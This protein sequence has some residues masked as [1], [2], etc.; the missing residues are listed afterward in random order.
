M[1]NAEALELRI[2]SGNHAGA[3]EALGASSQSLGTSDECDFVLSDAGLLPQQLRLESGPAGWCLLGCSD[4]SEAAG[5]AVALTPGV[6]QKVG[7]L[8]I[9]VDRPQAPWPTAQQ[10]NAL[11]Q[12]PTPEAH[13]SAALASPVLEE[14]AESVL[15]APSE[16][17][18]LAL[19]A[20]TP[21]PTNSPIARP[22]NR[23]LIAS[24]LALIVCALV[25][26]L[27]PKMAPQGANAQAHVTAPT[28]EAARSAIDA[29]IQAQGLAGRV[30][31]EPDAPGKLRVRAALLS[32]DEYE[33]LALA[34]SALRP[35]PALTVTT[36][37]DLQ[38]MVGE[39]IARQSGE[40][41]T[42]IVVRHMGGANFRIEGTLANSEERNAFFGRLKNDLPALVL[43]ESALMTPEDLAQG[44]LE[45][46]RGAKLAEINGHWTGERLQMT[47]SVAQTEVPRWEQLLAR[48]A[49]NH[50]VPFS[51]TLIPQKESASKRLPLA[52]ASLPFHV[53][54]VVS[55]ATPYVVIDGGEKLLIDG[56]VHGW[57]L[58]SV[59]PESVV[60]EGGQAKRLLVER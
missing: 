55:G 48:V 12:R 8:V 50:K 6:L 33:K 5:A 21:T 10:I 30:S 41:S 31:T 49:P 22:F 47:V 11:L 25:W 52:L 40:L 13:V 54:S 51:V 38:L 15:L 1:D 44:L 45:E 43:L 42:P 34:L 37:Q 17:P 24:L 16:V 35:R 60:F 53:Q 7:P 56:R 20:P 39:A 28:T 58:V 36:E 9:S 23:R 32:E 2:H 29:I 57:R 27:L 46:L 14:A 59:D 26:V 4:A 3:S 18:V 19:Q